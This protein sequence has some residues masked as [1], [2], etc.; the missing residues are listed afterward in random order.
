MRLPG[1]P[2]QP[3]FEHHRHEREEAESDRPSSAGH[4]AAVALDRTERFEKWLQAVASDI[5]ELKD[6]VTS[7][8]L[9]LVPVETAVAE[10]KRRSDQKGE[11][12]FRNWSLL[13]G[14]VVAI[15]GGGTAIWSARIQATKPPEVADPTSEFDKMSKIADRAAEAAVSKYK[16]EVQTAGL[17]GDTITAK[18]VK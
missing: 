14:L 9:R 5:S 3:T 15:I 16:R 6:G 8:N 18:S 11:H 12:T 1:P 7:F 13:V 17:P 10:L 2:R 4:E